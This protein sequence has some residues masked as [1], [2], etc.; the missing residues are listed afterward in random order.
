MFANAPVITDVGMQLLI[1]AAGGE[2]ITFTKLQVG[3]GNLTGSETPETMTALKSVVV[4]D[5]A[6]T[7]S[8]STA[9]GYVELSGMFDNLNDVAADFVWTELGLIAEDENEVEYLYGYGYSGTDGEFIKAGGT[10]KIEEYI[11]FIIAVGDSENI[12][13][14]VIADAT[15]ASKAAFDA[16]LSDYQNPHHVTYSQAGAAAA[17]HT[18]NA[19]AITSGVLPPSRGGT[20]VTS[21]AAL[22]ALIGGRIQM[23]KFLGDGTNRQ[24]IT[25]GYKPQFVMLFNAR[26]GDDN[27]STQYQTGWLFYDGLCFFT[28]SSGATETMTADQLFALGKGGAAVTDTGFAVGYNGNEYMNRMN[29]SGT[30]YVYIVKKPD[31]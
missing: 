23:G 22:D 4:D 21:I 12:T 24:D 28:P 26:T 3:D 30:Y 14:N 2:K 29:T 31:E 6:I 5:I 17:S 25:L 18:H 13:A 9:Q 1:R 19:S 15:Y 16:H 20:G 11:N 10:V 7:K 27:Y 8:V